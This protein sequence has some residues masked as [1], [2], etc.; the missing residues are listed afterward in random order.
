[1]SVLGY[2]FSRRRR[3]LHAAPRAFRWDRDGDANEMRALATMKM[4]SSRYLITDCAIAS[5]FNAHRPHR[6]GHSEFF[7]TGRANGMRDT[8]P[9]TARTRACDGHVATIGMPP[10]DVPD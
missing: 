7:G 8:E 3:R 4:L 2:R 5:A 10:G 6:Q 1:M 9:G